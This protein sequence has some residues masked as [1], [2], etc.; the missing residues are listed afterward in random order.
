MFELSC[1]VERVFGIVSGNAFYV[2]HRV[3]SYYEML[4]LCQNAERR[5]SE[6]LNAEFGIND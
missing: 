1:K 4:V 2:V 6:R 5:N 3:L